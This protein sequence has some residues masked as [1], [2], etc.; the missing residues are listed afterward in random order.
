MK[1]TTTT[2]KLAAV[3]MLLLLVVK[4]L[5]ASSDGRP[6]VT[7]FSEALC[8]Y[9]RAFTLDTLEP[10]FNKGVAKL[11]KLELVP[12]GNARLSPGPGNLTWSCQ[13]GETECRLN[14][15]LSCTTHHYP[16][17]E[18]WF[19]YLACLERGAITPAAQNMEQLSSKCA[20]VASMDPH[21]IWQCHTGPEGRALQLA[22]GMKTQALQPPHSGVPWVTMTSQHGGDSSHAVPLYDAADALLSLVCAAYGGKDRL[23]DACFE[24]PDPTLRAGR[25]CAHSMPEL[26]EQA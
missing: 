11:M 9:C 2:G 12:W 6:Q 15:L 23:P 5:Q 13:H 4:G 7:F 16:D 10:M 26:R 21:T 1:W 24:E 3:P 14:S 18:E 19:P 8:P 17:Q 25:K 20:A 22:A